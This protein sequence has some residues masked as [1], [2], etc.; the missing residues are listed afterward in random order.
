MP[1]TS[2][3]KTTTYAGQY[4]HGNKYNNPLIDL[5]W[6]QKDALNMSNYAIHKACNWH[7]KRLSYIMSGIV[8]NL[9]ANDIFILAQ[10]IKVEPE[11]IL[12]AI[13]LT[14]KFRS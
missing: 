5:I 3:R 9:R 13:G 12:H 2:H 4:R 14:L 10:V 1:T 11:E 8:V 6:R 7:G